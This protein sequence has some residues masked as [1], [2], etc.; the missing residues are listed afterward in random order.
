MYL[1]Q[2]KKLLEEIHMSIFIQI[3]KSTLWVCTEI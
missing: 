2:N 3:L 1:F